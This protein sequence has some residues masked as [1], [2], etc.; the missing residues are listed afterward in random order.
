MSKEFPSD[1]T[2]AKKN[3]LFFLWQAPTHHSFIFNLQFSYELKHKARV[4]LK[5]CVGFSNFASVSFLLKFISL[6]N[7]MHGFFDFETS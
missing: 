1:K 6:F 4:S 2:N 3:T 5:L 7:K